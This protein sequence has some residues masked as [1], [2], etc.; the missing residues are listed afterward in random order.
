[1]ER[2]R[3]YGTTT[4]GTGTTAGGGPADA[5]AAAD[6]PGQ[7][8]RPGPA[9]AGPVR[10]DGGGAS[11]RRLL[12]VGVAAVTGAFVTGAAGTPPKRT[13]YGTPHGAPHGAPY[14]TPPKPA[15]AEPS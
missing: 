11:R 10:T 12:G 5:P 8:V 7:E 14:G 2:T 9:T 1:M 13:P 6:R 4:A 3:T 15:A